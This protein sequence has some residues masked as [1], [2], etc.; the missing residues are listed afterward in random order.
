MA[1]LTVLFATHNGEKTLPQ[2]LDA[3]ENVEPPTG[4]QIKIVAVD[5]ASTDRSAELV[6]ARS[7][8]LHITLLSEARPGKNIALNKGLSEIEGD[9]VVL[10]DDDIVPARDWLISIRRIAEHQPSYDIF[11]GAIYPLWEEIPEEWVLRNVP[12]G[13]FGWT[14]FDEGPVGP[15]DV[16]GGN[17]AVRSRVFRK[18]R[19]FEGIGPNGTA[20]YA[21][22]SEVEFTRRAAKNGHKCWHSR[23]SVVGHIVRAH[24]L[25]PEWLLQRAYNQARGRRRIK[26][27][28]HV[29]DRSAADIMREL[30]SAIFDLTHASLFGSFEDKFKTKFRLRSL[31]ADLTERWAQ[32]FQNFF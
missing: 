23:S 24:Q 9:L 13:W 15:N 3:L 8:K 28:Y 4:D 27:I 26:K 5:S 16:W 25:T 12:K 6:K 14:D 30:F 11:G 19:F 31:Q 18:H 10:T 20:T 29:E 17:M 7:R 1:D 22:G 21:S 2:M 32:T